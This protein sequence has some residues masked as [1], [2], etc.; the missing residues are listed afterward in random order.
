LPSLKET[1]LDRTKAG[2]EAARARGIKHKLT[3]AQQKT[4]QTMYHWLRRSSVLKITPSKK[5]VKHSIFLNPHFIN[6]SG[7]KK[8]KHSFFDGIK[9]CAKNRK[10]S[11]N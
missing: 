1:S 11:Q 4:L 6:I 5:F 9:W 10:I 8:N 3:P 7:S 2:L